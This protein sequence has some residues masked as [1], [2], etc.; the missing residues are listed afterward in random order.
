MFAI[1]RR[2]CLLSVIFAALALCVTAC[3]SS[4]SSSSSSGG[5]TSSSGGAATNGASTSSSGGSSAVAQANAA[6]ATSTALPKYDGPTT[7]VDMSKLKGKTIMLLE[8][9]SAVP[10]VASTIAGAGEAAKAAGINTTTFDGM[11]QPPEWTRGIEQGVARGVA[12]IFMCGVPPEVVKS[13]LAQAKKANIPVVDA[14]DLS[15]PSAPLSPPGLSGARRSITSTTA[16]CSA[17][18]LWRTLAA[19]PHTS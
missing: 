4:S 19:P 8:G 3:G 13:A 6:L 10:F 1:G 2:H 11:G 18:T 7:P 12:G 17:T 5:T 15:S 16:P 9:N 14:F